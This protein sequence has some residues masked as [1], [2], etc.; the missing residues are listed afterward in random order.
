MLAQLRT[1][2]YVVLAA[3]RRQ[4]LRKVWGM[5]IG[6]GAR[7]SGKA[8]LDYTNPGGVHIG[9]YTIVTPGARIFTHD[10]VGAHHDNTHIGSC[11]F[12]GANAIIMPAVK[13][14]DH[15]IVAAGSVV[16]GHVPDGTMVA[17]NPAR[18]IKTGIVTGHYGRTVDWAPARNDSARNLPDAQLSDSNP[19]DQPLNG[20]QD[21]IQTPEKRDSSNNG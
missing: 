20:G 15:C 17:G 1:R 13:I 18:I 2:I 19:P 9:D 4:Y 21:T 7:I 8:H 14:G 3:L 12:I 10:Y 5:T 16:T 6:K 11:C